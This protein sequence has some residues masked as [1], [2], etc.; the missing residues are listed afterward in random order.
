MASEASGVRERIRVH[1]GAALGCG[2]EHRPLMGVLAGHAGSLQ[3]SSILK[4]FFF[5]RESNLLTTH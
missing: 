2:Q 1:T 4:F 5:L 3:S